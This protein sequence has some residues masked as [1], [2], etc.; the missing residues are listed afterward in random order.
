MCQRNISSQIYFKEKS[1]LFR[2]F[3]IQNT[4]NQTQRNIVCSAIPEQE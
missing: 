2:L 1:Q 4:V 3:L